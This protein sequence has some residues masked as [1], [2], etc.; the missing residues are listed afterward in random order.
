[1]F[2]FLSRFALCLC[3]AVVLFSVAPAQAQR[4]SAAGPF[5][6]GIVLGDPTAL[7]GKYNLDDRNAFDFGLAFDFSKWNLI[8]GDWHYMFPG[9]FRGNNSFV[10]QLSPYVGV[11]GILVM[12]NQDTIE[13]RKQRYFNSTTDSRMALGVRI[14][15]GIEWRTPNV[16][17]GVFI[18]IVPGIIVIPQTTSFTNAGLGV[19]YFF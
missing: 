14:P 17:L 6:F 10:N 7:T 15:L 4:S 5:G 8:Y 11:G 18:E 16:P 13:T 12:S 9:G 19:R 1:M 3:A 2:K